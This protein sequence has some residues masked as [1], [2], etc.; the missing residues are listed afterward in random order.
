VVRE[1]DRGKRGRSRVESRGKNLGAGKER[2]KILNSKKK[3]ER[4]RDQKERERFP[5]GKKDLG[6]LGKVHELAEERFFLEKKRLGFYQFTK[7]FSENAEIQKAG[8]GE[9][10]S[11]EG[12]TGGGQ[13][14]ERG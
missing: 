11:K 4:F 3:G 9:G 10:Q 8:Q 12:T 6:I 5:E 7:N 2:G 1:S 13:K 14:S